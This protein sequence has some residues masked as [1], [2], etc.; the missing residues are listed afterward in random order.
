M[1]KQK[2]YYLENIYLCIVDIQDP[3][4][5]SSDLKCKENRQYDEHIPQKTQKCK[6]IHSTVQAPIIEIDS[7][8]PVDLKKCWELILVSLLFL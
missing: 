8:Y 2:T 4:N 6:G 3:S 7:L 1:I 5:L